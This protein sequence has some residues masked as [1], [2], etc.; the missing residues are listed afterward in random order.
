M[1]YDPL[2]NN[3]FKMLGVAV[4][5]FFVGGAILR[6]VARPPAM[7]RRHRTGRTRPD[8]PDPVEKVTPP[9]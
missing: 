3:F 5:T 4:L 2:I 1:N 7:R 8:E 6:W 9:E